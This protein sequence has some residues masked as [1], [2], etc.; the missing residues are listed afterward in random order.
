[1]L[2]TS[3]YMGDI[4]GGLQLPGRYYPGVGLIYRYNFNDRIALKAN[5]LYGRIY[6]H[7]RDSKSEWQQNRNLHFRSDVFEISTQVEVNFLTYEIGDP[8]RPST[9]YL[10]AGIGL[11]RFNPQANFNDR[12]VD[13]Q[14]LGTE[15]Q[16]IEGNEDRYI[17]T[18]F[19]IPFGLGYKFNI[20]KGLAG[21]IEWGIRKTFTDYLD[22]VSG[23]YVESNL[24]EFENGPLSQIL[25]DRSLEPLGSDGTN[26]GYQR[27]ESN[28]KDWYIFTGI[29]LT[30]KIG[31]PRVK[32][33][34]TYN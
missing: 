26:D 6:A 21:A 1:M 7:D 30:Y 4:N 3:Y 28:R 31:K 9:P 20:Y 8:R 5:V 29:M 19:C 33:P 13:L 23:N 32:C 17:L 2:N 15:G 12:W 27:G 16:G 18:Q 34:T 24:L 11:F 14:P 25:A 10:F 22:D